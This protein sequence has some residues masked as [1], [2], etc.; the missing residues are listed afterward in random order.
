MKRI[1]SGEVGWGMGGGYEEKRTT[2]ILILTWVG[3][4]F[5]FLINQNKNIFKSIFA[6]L[7]QLAGSFS[8]KENALE[9]FFRSL[10]VPL[11]PSHLFY[12]LDCPLYNFE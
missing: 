11:I 7:G 6:N 5:Y 9:K 2:L 10:T 12:C 8:S 4:L 3:H 1:G